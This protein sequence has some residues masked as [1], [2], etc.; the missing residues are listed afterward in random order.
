MIRKIVFFFFFIPACACVAQNAKLKAAIEDLKKDDALK[1]ST[2]SVCV[3]NTKKDSAIVEYNSNV[4]VVP[5]STMKIVTTG[6]ALLMLGSDFMFQ[7]KIQYDGV[8]DS[9]SGVIKGNVYILGGGDPTLE[10]EYF[11]DKK[12]SLTTVEKWALILKAKG[13]KKI[14]GAIIGDASIFED[15]MTPSQWIW[16]DMGNYFGAGAC[17]LTYHDNKYT[18]IY[19]SGAAGTKTTLVTTIPAVADLQLVNNVVSGGSDDNAFIYGSQYSNYRTA[20]GTIPANQNNYEVDGSIPDPALFCAQAFETALKN[21]DVTIVKKSTT[22]RALR[23]AGT[24]VISNRK[25][26]HTN[27]SPT[28]DKIIY[29]TNL[30]SLNLYAEHLLKYICY[31]KTGV[32][33]ETQGTE[34]IT[35]FWKNKSVDVSGFFMNDGCGLA[36][37]NVITTKTETQILRL[38]SKDKNYN[39]FYNSLPVAGKSG[40]LGG[41]CDGTFAENNLRAKSGYITRA[42]GYAGYVKNRK[43]ELLCFSVLANNYECSPTE[44]KKK[45]EKILIA[46]AED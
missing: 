45:L 25:T 20:Q 12:D 4:S 9:V 18:A 14:E 8:F 6:A 30:K 35:N 42:R 22:V 27:Y 37:A 24:D 26:L 16:G 3:M 17:G 15:N 46:I 13:V 44:M 29:W 33:S 11:R 34:I 19:K 40:S 36:R 39:A 1:H 32:G 41:L 43:G 31:T 10:S 28:L 2:W 23:E 21:I 7:T 5:A 38:L